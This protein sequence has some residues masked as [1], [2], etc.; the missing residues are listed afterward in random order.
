MYIPDEGLFSTVV[1]V[2]LY[3][4]P[5]MKETPRRRINGYVVFK[6]KSTLSW[7]KDGGEGGRLYT[8]RPYAFLNR[9][10]WTNI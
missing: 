9:L 6:C 2:D 8:A 1:Q 5:A 3:L 4:C 10:Q 7:N